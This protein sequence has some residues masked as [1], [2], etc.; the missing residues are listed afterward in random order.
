MP[1]SAFD[2]D[3]VIISYNTAELCLACIDSIVSTAESLRVHIIV[4]DN[5]SDDDTASRVQSLHPSVTL[6]R[7]DVALGYAAA[8]NAGAALG[9][10]EL[11]IICNSDVEVQPGCLSHMFTTMQNTPAIGLCGAQQHYPDG[12]WQR[13]YGLIPGIGA[14]LADLSGMTFAWK[15]WKKWRFRMRANE[16]A[17]LTDVGYVD[18]A[19]IC[20]R[21]TLYLSVGGY[22]E[23][24]F[25]F[26]EDIKLS[27][28]VRSAGFRVVML[29]SAHIMHVR[30]AGRSMDQQRDRLLA[31]RNEEA[32]LR[33]MRERYGVT[34][35]RLSIAIEALYFCELWL[36]RS[37]L[38]MVQTA[39]TAEQQRV[40]A[41]RSKFLML[42]CTE[43][44]EQLE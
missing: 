1:T 34:L 37:V 39:Q 10:A 19:L 42:V 16:S 4:V 2:I 35:C 24:F 27:M 44:L 40:K 3:V 18:G 7:S 33:I 9:D 38:A 28:S 23:N 41:D 32:R 8:C 31:A 30:G 15:A 43:L 14:A 13:S 22:N 25:F 21:R 20:T 26:G 36:L 5:A 17:A 29:P 12:S 11:L 6:F